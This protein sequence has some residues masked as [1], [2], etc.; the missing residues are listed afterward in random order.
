[1]NKEIILQEIESLNRTLD[2]VQE[3]QSF[4]KSKL[5][6]FLDK[7]VLNDSLVWAETLHQEILNREAAIQLLKND[8]SKM[9]LELKTKRFVNNMLDAKIVAEFK[10]YKQQVGYIEIQ[11]LSWKQAANEKF[12][13]ALY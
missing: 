8:I 7:I 1:M 5:G 6:S 12:E 2:F 13:S 11:F 4:I 3:E 10:K 9:A